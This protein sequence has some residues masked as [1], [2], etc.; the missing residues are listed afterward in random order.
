MMSEME[1]T[2]AEASAQ[3]PVLLLEPDRWRARSLSLFLTHAGFV[4][5]LEP[6]NWPPPV[7]VLANLAWPGNE[8]RDQIEAL[9]RRHPEP[10][11]VVFVPV[12]SAETVFPSL[13][14]GVKGVVALNASEHELEAALSCVL[15]GS[16][17]APRQILSQWIDMMS[18]LDVAGGP[19]GVF[20][21]E[22]RR[23]LER[24]SEG[25]SNK[26]IAQRL[27]ITEATV[28]YHVGNL[29]KKTGASGRKGLL[30]LAMGPHA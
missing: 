9:K 29:L 6:A 23:V 12:L 15:S 26:E 7:A 17:W 30:R 11:V 24:L 13:R 1:N 19:L 20:T 3:R 16:I 2:E 28:K 21:P 4:A 14:L 22:Q 25:L 8:V 27:G 5:S 10:R 18:R